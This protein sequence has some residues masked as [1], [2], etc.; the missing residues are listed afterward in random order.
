MMRLL[1]CAS[2]TCLL[3]VAGCAN[4]HTIETE[5]D[6]GVSF[7]DGDVVPEDGDVADGDVTED[8]GG[9]PDLGPLPDG[10]VDVGVV[11]DLGMD[12]GPPPPEC[13]NDDECDD[14][15]VCTEDSC[16]DGACVN[17]NPLATCERFEGAQCAGDLATELLTIDQT[18]CIPGFAVNLPNVGDVSLCQGM[19]CDPSD[20]TDGCL[21]T[22][23]ST[24]MP[25]T[26]PEPNVLRV[27]G[28][29]TRI[30]GSVPFTGTVPAPG[31]GGTINL[32]CRVGFMV[33]SGLPIS[34]DL[35]LAEQMM[36]GTERD[37]T[38]E[39]DVDLS[40]LS[41]RLTGTGINAIICGVANSLLA[42]QVSTL[43]GQVEPTLE[44]GMNQA[45]NQLDCGTC[46]S[47][48]AADLTCVTQ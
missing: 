5:D 7:M 8:G 48:C 33:G 35:A 10:S 34:A 45:L 37:I 47:R 23:E 24:G 41:I 22:F 30:G 27:A 29:I 9:A 2:L 46:N 4:A 14:E 42:G 13:S 15:S 26:E 19:R 11:V 40:M 25:S 3:A 31:G 38:A 44:Q 43:L 20:T 17:D 12:Q 32:N 28:L 21:I 6:S 36:C 39:A 18:F 1:A 16:E